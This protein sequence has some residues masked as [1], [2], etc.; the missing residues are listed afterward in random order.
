[1]AQLLEYISHNRMLAA[2]TLVALAAVLVYEWYLRTLEQSAI[3]PQDAVRLMNQG[4][5]VLDVRPTTAFSSGHLSNARHLPLENLPEAAETLKRFKDRPV[6]VYCERGNTSAAAIRQLT[7]MGFSKLSSL[8]GGIAAW[9][10][11]NLP[12]V[13]P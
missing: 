12:L 7:T 10:A 9:R 6:I 2:L 5:T 13:R 11:E 4:A 8:R 1:M 3:S